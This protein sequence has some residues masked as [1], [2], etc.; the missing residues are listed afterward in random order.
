MTVLASQPSVSIDTDTTQRMDLPEA[1]LLANGVHHLSEQVLVSDVLR[2]AGASPVRSTL[3]LRKRSISSEAMVRKFL[4]SAS[5]DSI[6]S[7]SISTV[8]GMGYGLPCSSKFRNRARRPLLWD[9]GAVFALTME[10][11]DIVIH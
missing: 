6:C 1:S 7:L 10:A 2:I 9:R 3:S 5:P 11:R 8:R 4:S